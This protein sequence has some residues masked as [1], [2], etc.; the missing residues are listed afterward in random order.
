MSCNNYY[1]L[2]NYIAESG[3]YINCLLG[4][5]WFNFWY[6]VSPNSFLLK[7]LDNFLALKFPTLKRYG[8]E[9]AESMIVFVHYYMKQICNHKIKE[10]I[11]GMAHR[12]KS[13][14]LLGE[15]N[16]SPEVFCIYKQFFYCFQRLQLFTMVYFALPDALGD[17]H[18]IYNTW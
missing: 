14:V 13:N 18:T 3:R 12:G 1:L 17:F 9:G 5:N 11:I 7:V 8:A 10:L 6:N 15:L 4:E 16:F 2:G